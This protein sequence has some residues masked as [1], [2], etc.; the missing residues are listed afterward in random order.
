MSE[1]KGE[2]TNNIYIYICEKEAEKD[3]HKCAL[4]VL[5]RSCP[6][7]RT[8]PLLPNY[9]APLEEIDIEKE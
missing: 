1:E 4:S 7:N 3:E 6:Y 2:Q 9:V 5:T 8:A